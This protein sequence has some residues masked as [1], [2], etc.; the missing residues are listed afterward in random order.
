[1]IVQR[2]LDL[3][4][5]RIQVES[6]VGSGTTVTVHVPVFETLAAGTPATRTTPGQI[7]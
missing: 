5:G 6:V 4:R 1:V 2:C 7:G 3:H